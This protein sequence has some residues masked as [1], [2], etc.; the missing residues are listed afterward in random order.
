MPKFI[1]LDEQL[2][3]E[4]FNYLIEKPYKETAHLVQKIQTTGK[5]F[6]PEAAVPVP[7]KTTAQNNVP[8]QAPPGAVPNQAENT[9]AP[10][11]APASAPAPAPH[12]Q[13]VHA[14]NKFK[15]KK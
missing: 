4:L 7:P 11:P 5:L 13:V 12:Q 2:V 8:P 6:D 15:G 14:K 1:M 10:T 3:T 9:P